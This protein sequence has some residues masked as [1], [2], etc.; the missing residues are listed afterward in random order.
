MIL[1]RKYYNPKTK[2]MISLIKL[3]VFVVLFFKNLFEKISHRKIGK[4]KTFQNRSA[5]FRGTPQLKANNESDRSCEE[6]E[7]CV[8]VCPSSCME[9]G[10][11]KKSDQA[12]LKINMHKCLFCGLCE[13]ACSDQK[14]FFNNNVFLTNPDPN[15]NVILLKERTLQ[16]KKKA[17]ASSPSLDQ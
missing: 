7:L 15:K 5:R 3:R 17:S 6:C 10:K 12:L 4:S 1:D 2:L 13:E 16:N 9:L 8:L 11:D 14:L